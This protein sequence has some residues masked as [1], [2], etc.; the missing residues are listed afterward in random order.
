MKKSTLI[1][2][3]AAL[4]AAGCYL[5][6][7]TRK[8][9]D[10]RRKTVL[11]TGASSGLGT[12]FARIFAQHGFDIVLTARNQDKLDALAYELEQGSGIQTWV[13]PADL[14]DAYG[15]EQLYDAVKEKGLVIDQLVNNAGAGLHGTTTDTDPAAM[16]RL[17]ELN[18][19]SVTR[20]CRLFGQDMVK[21]GSGRIL[22]VSSI[23]AFGPDPQF[24][25]YGPSKAFELRLSETMYGELFGTGVSVSA[26]CPGPTKTQWARRAGKAD[27]H[28]A[29]DPYDVALAGFE[30]MQKGQLV[31]VPSWTLK[32]GMVFFR[33]L[34]VKLRAVLSSVWQ[35]SLIHKQTKL[36]KSH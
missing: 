29:A 11:I 27:S 25:V 18:V 8:Q 30:G 17:L 15:A 13:I 1:I 19:G 10:H 34:P 16:D 9:P 4:T 22:N 36:E 20:L 32:A 5:Y 2:G 26:L 7:R 23:G 24:N 12:E 31:I 21:R 28:F 3:A 33:C 14:S 35:K 6:S